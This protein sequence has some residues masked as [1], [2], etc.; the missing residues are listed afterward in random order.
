[1]LCLTFSTE[2]RLCRTFWI[3]EKTMEMFEE[4][5]KKFDMNNDTQI[6]LKK[7]QQ[8][9]KDSGFTYL[10]QFQGML[11]LFNDLSDKAEEHETFMILDPGFDLEDAMA[12]LLDAKAISFA[13]DAKSEQS[14][15]YRILK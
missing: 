2:L 1:M 12:M 9:L 13:K 7:L 10:K 3:N 14:F 6:D 4:T 8:K 11:K 5:Q 15:T